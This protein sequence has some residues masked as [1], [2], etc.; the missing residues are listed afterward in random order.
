MV[1]PQPT[2]ISKQWP[3]SCHIWG[4]HACHALP[5][6]RHSGRT[7]GSP[8]RQQG[9][10]GY[11]LKPH[12][13]FLYILFLENLTKS[14]HSPQLNRSSNSRTKFFVYWEN[15]VEIFPEMRIP[16]NLMNFLAHVPRCFFFSPIMKE[17]VS[18]CFHTAGSNLLTGLFWHVLPHFQD[19]NTV[20]YITLL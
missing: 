13:V 11:D 15:T 7:D 6:Q 3:S 9:S 5:S 4:R 16:L 14:D 19:T 20:N 8:H 2:K 10:L 1:L 17:E 18:H 12:I